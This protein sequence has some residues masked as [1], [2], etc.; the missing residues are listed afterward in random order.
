M[1]IN[2]RKAGL[3]AIKLAIV[4]G[5][6]GYLLAGGRLNFG[7]LLAAASNPSLLACA[8]ISILLVQPVGVARWYLL[9]RAQG[10]NGLGPLACAGIHYGAGFFDLFLLGPTGGDAVR[11]ALTACRTPKGTR[12]EA[13]ATILLDRV[14]GLFALLMIGILGI[15][16]WPAD[17][18]D[19]DRSQ[20]F[21]LTV[22]IGIAIISLAFAAAFSR[23][24]FE[25]TIRPIAA[26]LPFGRFIERAVASVHDY[27]D[28]PGTIAAGLFLSLTAHMCTIASIYF[29]ASAIGMRV[30]PAD[31]VSVVPICLVVN[32]IGPAGG[33][34][35][36]EVGFDEIFRRALGVEGGAAL[37][38]AYHILWAASKLPGLAVILMMGWPA[39]EA[40][41]GV[42]SDAE[43]QPDAGKSGKSAGA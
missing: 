13:A 4:A 31:C 33:W 23:F 41:A 25:R 14:L 10:G 39:A 15:L 42:G 43:K 1:G 8:A 36:G 28:R 40:K 24:L 9:M 6:I 20:A 19:G 37:A 12:V 2:W 22:G 11:A 35:V 38:M 34:G 30:S 29:L 7:D 26:R 17:R 5:G 16:M 3:I 18:G 27:R 32:A 21:L